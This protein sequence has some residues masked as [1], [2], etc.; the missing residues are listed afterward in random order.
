MELQQILEKKK[1]LL[2]K[3]RYH[4]EDLVLIVE[5]LRSEGGCPWDME[6]T[7]KSIRNDFIEETYAR[8]GQCPTGSN[9]GAAVS[10]PVPVWSCAAKPAAQPLPAAV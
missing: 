5:L 9:G 7:H 3:D 8:P 2:S 6:Q 4:F 10:F 1:E